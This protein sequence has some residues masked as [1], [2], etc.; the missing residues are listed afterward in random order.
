MNCK[1]KL[2]WSKDEKFWH[3]ESMDERFGLTLESGSLD[4]LI[5]RVKMAVPEMFD[6]IGYKGEINLQF[7]LERT[8]KI[9]PAA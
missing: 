3:S 2:I 1:I 5:E 6:I 9:E 4:V 7:E 8:D